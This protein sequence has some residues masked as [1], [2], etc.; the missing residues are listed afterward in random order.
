MTVTTTLRYLET[1]VAIGVLEQVS[2]TRRYR[3]AIRWRHDALSR[4]RPALPA[5][6]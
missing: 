4:P 1:W 6:T 3:L 2:K 5:A